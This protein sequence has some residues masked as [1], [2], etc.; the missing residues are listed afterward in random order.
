MKTRW[1]GNQFEVSA[2]GLGCMGMSFGY[3]G[4]AER[5]SMATLERAVELGVTLFDTAEVYGPFDNE[6]LLGKAL[7]RFRDRIRIATKF[8]FK[9]S[10]H[11]SGTERM[12]GLDSRP[13]HVKAVAEASLKRLGVDVIDLF[14]QH[15]VD[16]A[17]PI[18]DTVGAMADLVKAGKVRALG[19]S[20][21]APDTIRRAHAVHP[22]SAVQTEYSL[23]SRDVEADVLPLCHELGI[24][25]VPYSPLGRG[26]LT[27]R[28]RDEHMRADDFRLT[29][30]RFQHDN[31]ARNRALADRLAAVA[32]RKHITVAQLVLAW[33]LAQGD[34]IV[35]IPGSRTIDHLEDNVAAA[36]VV[37][38]ADDLAEIERNFP[39]HDVAGA[40]Y[41]ESQMAIIDR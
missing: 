20:E 40:R 15:R 14:Y 26:L 10:E 11:G 27:G 38:S 18:E 1:I 16:P 35:P 7:K 5:G 9:I 22:I 36:D 28:L 13:E 8:G 25:F 23:S 3:G 29:L 21:A 6:L 19:L 4:Q 24:T 41:A 2:V 34:R 17:V 33:V 12:V 32:A 37:L 31:L 30:P 39:L